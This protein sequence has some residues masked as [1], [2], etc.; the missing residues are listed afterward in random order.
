MFLK[1]GIQIT[2]QIT[3]SYVIKAPAWDKMAIGSIVHH[4]TKVQFVILVPPSTPVPQNHL[5]NT[6]KIITKICRISLSN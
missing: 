1:A 4:L 3:A 6:L 2:E 5:L